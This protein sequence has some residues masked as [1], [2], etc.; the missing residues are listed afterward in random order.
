MAYC[1]QIESE[2][3]VYCYEMRVDGKSKW[4]THWVGFTET[5]SDP[6][7]YEFRHRLKTIRS[8]G[9]LVPDRVFERIEREMAGQKRESV[10]TE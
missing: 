9:Y 10:V 7:L 5:F 1:R 6:S 3:D 2:C 4:I 8:Y